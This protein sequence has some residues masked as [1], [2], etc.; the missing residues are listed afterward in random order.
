MNDPATF[1]ED[2]PHGVKRL[3]MG[4]QIEEAMKSAAE[5]YQKEIAEQ[6]VID[7]VEG[8]LASNAGFVSV[9]H[10]KPAA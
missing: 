9:Q 3:S 7:D 1:Y 10:L 5:P 8:D 2:S 6:R 4:G